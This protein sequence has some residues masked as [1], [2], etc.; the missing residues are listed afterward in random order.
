MVGSISVPTTQACLLLASFGPTEPSS[1]SGVWFV[2]RNAD[3]PPSDAPTNTHRSEMTAYAGYSLSGA[4]R[5]RLAGA[6][7]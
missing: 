7:A 5:L 6:P 2:G 3:T 4:V 1:F